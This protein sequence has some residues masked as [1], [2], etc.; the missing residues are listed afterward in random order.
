[1]ESRPLGRSRCSLPHAQDTCLSSPWRLP[2][3]VSGLWTARHALNAPA[4]RKCPEAAWQL[5]DAAD[6][7]A[8]TRGMGIQTLSV[9]D[10]TAESRGFTFSPLNARHGVNGA[11]VLASG[12]GEEVW[13]A[14]TG[15]APSELG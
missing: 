5:N 11:T 3:P 1:M 10:K 15:R 9:A 2:L 6:L 14:G 13:L 4:A 7:P 8:P 12:R